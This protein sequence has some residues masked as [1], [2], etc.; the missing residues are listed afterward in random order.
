MKTI[1]GTITKEELEKYGGANIML[2]NV[3]EEVSSGPISIGGSVEITYSLA[4]TDYG[5]TTD[6]EGN[7]GVNW[8]LLD[9]FSFWRTFFNGMSQSEIYTYLAANP[10]NAGAIAQLLHQSY[11]SIPGV[12]NCY[13]YEE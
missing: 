7:G 11:G 1:S 10:E 13:S 6:N 9:R 8:E 5:F 12:R 2:M 4:W 3:G